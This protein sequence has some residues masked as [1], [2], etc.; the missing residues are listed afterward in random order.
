MRQSH[1]SGLIRNYSKQKQNWRS[2]K[3]SEEN[4]ILI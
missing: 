1:E 4:L 3:S 2:F